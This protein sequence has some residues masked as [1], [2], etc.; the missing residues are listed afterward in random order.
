MT[1]SSLYVEPFLKLIED[2]K[3]KDIDVTEALNENDIKLTS[4]DILNA[5]HHQIILGDPGAGKSLLVK[6]IMLKIFE[7]SNVTPF[8][9]ELRKYIQEYNRNKLSILEY[10]QVLLSTEYQLGGVEKNLLE[11]II[12]N[13]QTVFLFDGLDEI[14]DISQKEK[15]ANDI[16]NFCNAYPRVKGIVT[17]RFIGFNDVE[18]D[19]EHFKKLSILP[20]IGSQVEEFID[21]FFSTQITNKKLRLQEADGCK[22]QI[23]NVSV[24]LKSNPLILSLMSMLALNNVQIP[25]SRLEVYQSITETLVEKRDIEEKELKFD[26]KN[27][28]NIKGAFSSLAYWQYCQNSNDKKATNEMAILHIADYLFKKRNCDDIEEAKESAEKFIKYAEQRSIYFDNNFTHKTFSEYYTANFICMNYNNNPANLKLRDQVIKDNLGDPAWHVVFEL[29]FSMIDK[30]VDDYEV[31][32]S[33]FAPHLNTNTPLTSLFLLSQVRILSNMDKELIAKVFNNAIHMLINSKSVKNTINKNKINSFDDDE[34]KL[35]HLLGSYVHA[36]C[37]IDILSQ[38]M[39][40]IEKKIESEANR[41]NFYSLACSLDHNGSNKLY[42]N[43]KA[44]EGAASH[45]TYLYRELY[46]N[47]FSLKH[48]MSTFKSEELFDR[49]YLKFTGGGFYIGLVELWLK[50][51]PK[52]NDSN[53]LL[54][55]VDYIVLNKKEGL[56]HE[57]MQFSHIF[58]SLNGTF[59][60]FECYIN[61]NNKHTELFEEMIIATTRNLK[62]NS[63]EEGDS[64]RNKETDSKILKLKEYIA[65]LNDKN[66]TALLDSILS[67]QDDK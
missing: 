59:N 19:K 13:T 35:F 26:I 3:D 47:D 63:S 44:F 37:K 15:T 31:I 54:L 11:A 12:K 39:M 7:L 61:I 57:Y 1:I 40:Q 58:D 43:K 56:I 16:K 10:L 30:Q 25:D 45:D 53:D 65:N 28:R 5:R 52:E 20:F 2:K 48:A 9:I 67:E 46:K 8:R 4:E 32:T 24:D 41:I 23:K 64:R 36:N 55:I 17:S 66:S 60:L 22:S 49:I 6:S 34:V 51:D 38:V 50:I 62:L 18:F 27:I 33:L 42:C 21:N 14:F 29:L